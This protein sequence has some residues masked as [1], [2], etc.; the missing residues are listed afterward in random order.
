[1]RLMQIW[2]QFAKPT[3][4]WCRAGRQDNCSLVMS[5]YALYDQDSTERRG[6][7]AGLGLLLAVGFR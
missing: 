2:S 5:I 6:F 3:A 4:P 1:M 7:F